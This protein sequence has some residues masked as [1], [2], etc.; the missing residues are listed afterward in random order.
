MNRVE[1]YLA[2]KLDERAVSGNLRKLS[3]H[4]ANI[5]FFSNDYL[6][7]V[8]TGTLAALMHPALSTVHTTGSTGSRLLSGNSVLAEE[9]EQTIATFHKADAALIFNSGYDANVGLM[10]SIVSR[11]TIILSDELCHASL[12]DGIRLSQCNHK[13]KFRHNDLDDLEHKLQTHKSA[14]P[15]LVVVESIYSMDG[16]AAPLRDL[17]N[18]CEQYEAQLVVDE[19]H[20]TGIFGRNGEG[21]VCALGLQD[22]VFARIHTF[23]KALG[24]HGAAVVGSAM[25]KQYLINFARSFIYTTALP[26]HSLHAVSCA[27]QYLAGHS[28]SN[29]PLHELIAY[30][31]ACKKGDD[32]WMGS[33]SQIQALVVGDNL[34][35]KE[36]ATKL[37]QA[38]MQVNPILHPT[39]PLGKERLRVCLHTYNTKEQVDLFFACLK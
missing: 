32:R 4:R 7:L 6:G 20:A 9:R 31:N 17:V 30:F 23:G 1:K 37:Q 10:A 26:G 25:L 8:T 14:G 13:Y 24:C 34:F 5:D 18:L 33:N 16:D 3:T 22:K 36:I 12:I 11:D 39:V 21:L 35:S 15:I 27:Y 29:E 38:G 28:F 2:G 19:A